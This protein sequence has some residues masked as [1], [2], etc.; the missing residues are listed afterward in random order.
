MSLRARQLLLLVRPT[1]HAAEWLAPIAGSVLAVVADTLAGRISPTLG[2]ELAAIALALGVSFALD[3]PAA[4]ST[5]ASPAPLLLRHAVRA[6][7]TL[8]LPVAV[9][10]MLLLRSPAPDRSAL[11]LVLSGLLASALAIAAVG[12]RV[13]ESGGFIAGPAFLALVAGAFIL[14]ERVSLF[15][16]GQSSEEKTFLLRWALVLGLAASTSVAASLE[17]G[18]SRRISAKQLLHIRT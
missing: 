10:L 17:S 9:W 14:P 12:A 8:P 6:A 13:G 15:P 5:A 1:A 2:L 16:E 4:A 18:S 7:C 3:D 11:T